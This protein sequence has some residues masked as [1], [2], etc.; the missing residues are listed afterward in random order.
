MVTFFVMSPQLDFGKTYKQSAQLVQLV[1]LA[2]QVQLVQLARRA[3]QVLRA[4]L[5]LPDQLEAQA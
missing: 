5:A 3:L 4:Q 2:Q 1:L